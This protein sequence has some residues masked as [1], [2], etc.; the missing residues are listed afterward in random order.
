MLPLDSGT[1]APPPV[2][3][4]IPHTFRPA[5]HGG[6]LGDATTARL[7]G[8][9]LH[10]QRPHVASSW[11]TL[12]AVI[13]AGASPWQ[14]PTLAVSVNPAWRHGRADASCRVARA[15]LRAWVAG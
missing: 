5:F 7:V 1:S 11:T 12:G 3:F 10:G 13:Q 15:E 8:R 6:L 4:G 2:E 9:V 14:V